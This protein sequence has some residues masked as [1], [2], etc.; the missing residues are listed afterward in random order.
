MAEQPSLDGLARKTRRKRTVA[1]RIPAKKH[2]IARVILDVQAAHL[3]RTFDYLIAQDQ[4]ESAQPGAFVRVRFGAQKLIGVIWSRS[5]H[6]D[7]PA[8]ALRF[9]ERVLPSD[10]LL[11]KSLRDDI[12]AIAAAYG[13]TSANILRLAVPQRVARVEHETVFDNIRLQRRKDWCRKLK[14][15]LLENN[16][17]QSAYA[18]S[19]IHI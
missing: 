1:E 8:S 19:L 10:V 11:S 17:A 13:G 14:Q 12:D 4:D 6:T 18:L 16:N 15:R 7:T 5:S 3:G 9:I 2:A